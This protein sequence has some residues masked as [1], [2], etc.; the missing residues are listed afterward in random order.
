[1]EV[2]VKYSLCMALLVFSLWKDKSNTH[3]GHI[4]PI[5]AFQ[6]EI[7]HQYRNFLFGPVV[8]EINSSNQINYIAV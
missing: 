1:M 8:P 5:T 4:K 6:P 2:Y 3:T 7:S